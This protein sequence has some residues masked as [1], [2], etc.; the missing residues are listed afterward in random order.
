M[1]EALIVAGHEL[2]AR[3]QADCL[4][5]YLKSECGLRVVKTVN[6][7][8][9]TPDGL[10][11]VLIYRC[12][13]ARWRPL[14]IAYFGHGDARGWSYGKRNAE[15]W[16]E[17]SYRHVAALRREGADPRLIGAI[18]SS[19]QDGVSCGD[20]GGRILASWRSRQA[21]VPALLGGV[22]DHEEG[23]GHRPAGARPST[24]SSSRSPPRA[25][26]LGNL[27]VRARS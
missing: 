26:F 2:D 15:A 10:V 17:L 22:P 27:D 25:S 3:E 21:Y 18:A 16:L 13:S 9:R 8:H 7:S 24:I 5:D 6:A 19:A 1:P 4:R 12:V 23:A 20:M 11:D 14:L